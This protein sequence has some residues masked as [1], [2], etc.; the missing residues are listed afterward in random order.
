MK[1]V[2]KIS[3]LASLWLAMSQPKVGAQPSENKVTS[4]DTYVAYLAAYM[5]GSDEHSLYYAIS[6]DG[7]KFKELNHGV[8]ILSASYDDQLIRD[9]HLLRTPNNGFLLVATVSWSHRPFT[10]W[11][12]ADLVT[13]VGERLVD[14]AP[15]GA[16]KTWA[17]ELIYDDQ[18]QEYMA[19]WTAEIGDDWNTASIYCSTTPDLIN[20]SPSRIL[21]QMPNS[22]ILDANITKMDDRYVML[23]RH[24]SQ[25]HLA[26][27]NQAVGP[28]SY[29]GMVNDENVEGPFVFPLIDG[30]GWGYVF[31]Y[32]GESAGFGFLTTKDLKSWTRLTNPAYPYYNSLVEFPP[33]IRHGSIIGITQSELDR[34][35]NAFP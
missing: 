34:L 4:A 15:E 33:G 1:K 27:A 6:D 29:Q 30:S 22:G 20:W 7:F 32:F 23:F 3:L 14:I 10:L 17:P 25:I 28:Y 11:E 12:S 16:T 21:F 13:W 31:D 8:P 26:T 24:Q 9:P 35:H 19:Y 18:R 5:K 2:W